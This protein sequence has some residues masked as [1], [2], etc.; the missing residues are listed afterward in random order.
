MYESGL[1]NR[2]GE[3]IT[4]NGMSL[5]I[6][7]PFYFGLIRIKKT[8]D[9]FYGAHQPLIS[10]VLFNRVQDV[11][12]GK[13]RLRN[14]RH[15]LLFRRFLTCAI[16]HH[17]LLGEVHK[18]HVYYRCQTRGCPV[19]SVRQEQ[20]EKHTNQILHSIRPA[21]ALLRYFHKNVGKLTAEW[22]NEKQQKSSAI[23]ASLNKIDERL[24][25]LTDVFLDNLIDK[26][27][28][29]QRK[30]ALLNERRSLED[31]WMNLSAERGSAV[32]GIAYFLE[33]AKSAY[34][35]YKK[36][37]N[38]E[39]RVLLEKVI[40]NR[41]FDGKNILFK[42]KYPFDLLSFCSE[43][44]DGSP[45]QGHYRTCFEELLAAAKVNR[46]QQDSCQVARSMYKFR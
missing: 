19:R 33:L 15:D 40:S 37:S 5:L 20:V 7:N 38:N 26:E 31:Q 16:C 36:G 18:G 39:K 45:H 41:T 13:H 43:C 25:K 32:A 35:Q 14:S 34:L 2:K 1:R 3:R 23:Q 28:F 44:P 21:P 4:R 22:Q 9:T 6:N 27:S 30:T 11:R 10:K 42:P 46:E 24:N 29:G 17:H 8:G 12:H